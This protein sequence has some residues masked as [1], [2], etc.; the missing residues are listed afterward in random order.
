MEFFASDTIDSLKFADVNP[1]SF[2]LFHLTK[3]GLRDYIGNINA[4]IVLVKFDH[5]LLPLLVPGGKKGNSYVC[6]PHTHYVT[7][8][9]ESLETISKPALRFGAAIGLRLLGLM[10]SC[11]SVNKVVYL[12]HRL[13][14]TDLHPGTLSLEQIERLT[15]ALI[16]QFPDRAIV[17]RSLNSYTNAPFMRQ[18]D[19]TGYDFIA[20]R[21]TYVTPLTNGEVFNNRIIKSDLKL[22]EE[23]ACDIINHSDFTKSDSARVADLC[24]ILANDHHSKWNPTIDAR[25]IELLKLYPSIKVKAIKIDGQIVGAIGYQ[26]NDQGVITSTIF[27]YDKNHP[28]Q[29]THYRLLSTLLL[30]EAKK[31]ATIFNQSAGGSYFKKSRGAQ[32][33][34]EYQAVYTKHLNRRQNA[35]WSLLKNVI[36]KFAPDLMKNY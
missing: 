13:L 22:W 18:L 7:V 10:L 23:T 9:I 24:R 8:G 36:N 16:K 3:A 32:G 15:D 28:D 35:G 34:T 21:H 14:S 17:I 33:Y 4:E 20:S 27:G 6:S 11:T 19:K 30:L 25:F 2:F 31:H 1:E 29:N 5:H 26:I 12:N